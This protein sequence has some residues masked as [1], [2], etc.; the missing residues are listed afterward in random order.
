MLQSKAVSVGSA[1]R[2]GRDAAPVQFD[3]ERA[4]A[5]IAFHLIDEGVTRL[6]QQ[7]SMQRTL[8]RLRQHS[9]LLSISARTW[10]VMSNGQRLRRLLDETG[11]E[12][13]LLPDDTA[14]LVQRRLARR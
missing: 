4:V 5:G 13:A 9:F 14:I 8:I 10:A 12:A 11:T 3:A 6:V 7:D 2:V 1:G